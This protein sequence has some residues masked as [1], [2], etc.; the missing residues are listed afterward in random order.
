MPTQ[1]RVRCEQRTKF[2]ESLATEDFACDCQASS[3]VV[4]EQD[5]LFVELLFEH[6][7]FGSQILDHFLLLAVDPT[8][9]DDDV[10]LPR[11]KNEIHERVHRGEVHGNGL[12]HRMIGLAVQRYVPR[13]YH[14]SICRMLIVRSG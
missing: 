8:G 11:L 3:L 9:E 13:G 10:E 1:N 5:P 7:V 14:H 6:L 12:H 4:I 2:L